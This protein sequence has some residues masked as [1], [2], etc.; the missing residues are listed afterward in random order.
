MGS[1]IAR[2]LP[3]GK[4]VKLAFLIKGSLQPALIR[5]AVLRRHCAPSKMTSYGLG[6]RS[7]DHDRFA[8]CWMIQGC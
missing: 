6:S 2:H 1:Q 8:S 5:Q 4:T 3:I 7:H